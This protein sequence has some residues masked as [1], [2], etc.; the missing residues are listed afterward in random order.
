MLFAQCTNTKEHSVF[1]MT[2][3]RQVQLNDLFHTVIPL[4]NRKKIEQ[5]NPVKKIES[6]FIS[7]KHSHFSPVNLR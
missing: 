6:N 5:L 4:K 3:L 2:I 1:P 7:A